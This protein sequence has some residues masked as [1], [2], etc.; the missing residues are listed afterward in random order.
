MP[1]YRYRCTKCPNEFNA[2]R[3]VELRDDVLPCPLCQSQS[4]R[5]PSVTS[6]QIANGDVQ[7]TFMYR[8]GKAM[9]RA[10]EERQAHEARFGQ[11]GEYM[12][13]IPQ[14]DIQ[15]GGSEVQSDEPIDVDRLGNVTGPDADAAFDT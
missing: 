10:K 15:S 12:K 9:S 3:E 13:S 11:Y 14:P 1:T 8:A 4:N 5:I 2:L 6:V 7:N